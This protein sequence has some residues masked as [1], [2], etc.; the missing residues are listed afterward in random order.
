LG[1]AE[2]GLPRAAIVEVLNLGQERRPYAYGF[3]VDHI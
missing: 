1:W 2:K 3:P